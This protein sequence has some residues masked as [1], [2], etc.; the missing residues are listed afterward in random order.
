MITKK[1]QVCNTEIENR[2]KR[3]KEDDKG[4]FK[5]LSIGSDNK[6]V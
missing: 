3:H 2:S 5:H 6:D 4:F 1:E